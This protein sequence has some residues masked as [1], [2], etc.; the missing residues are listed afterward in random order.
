MLRIG[1]ADRSALPLVAVRAPTVALIMVLT[2]ALLAVVAVVPGPVP[3]RWLS[4]A[5][6]LGQAGLLV[7][8][9]TLP[10]GAGLAAAVLGGVVLDLTP[11]IG[12]G[13]APA[14]VFT[15]SALHPPRGSWP[16]AA[17]MAAVAPVSL[18]HGTRTGVLLGLTAA[19]AAWSLGALARSQRLQRAEALRSELVR[20]RAALARDVHD[21]VGH[22]LAVIIVQAGAAE[23][24]FDDD[25]AAAR[26]A[27]RTIDESARSALAEVRSVIA[28]ITRRHDLTDLTTLTKAAAA[29]GLTP[30][31]KLSGEPD[32]V[33]EPV[34]DAV[35]RIVR[36]A[37]TNAIR[38]S[39]GRRV[40]IDIRCG[41]SS[42]H[43]LISDDG[44]RIDAGSTPRPGTGITGMTELVDRLGGTIAFRPG[45]SGF[46]VRAR[47]P[48]GTR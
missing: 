47:L 6:V 26:T 32:V 44:G 17:A 24:G 42:V 9:P 7:L 8:V 41:P 20:Q 38:H 23:D 29:A 43:V 5:A 14:A 35:F 2:A 22:S 30:Q 37:V 12:M 34:A 15:A 13:L 21:I 27:L 19:V 36:E 4:A 39:G 31:L 1:S 10:I 46:V 25:P 48:L 33:P 16:A 45:R 3:S 28:G 11:V 18:V 40:R